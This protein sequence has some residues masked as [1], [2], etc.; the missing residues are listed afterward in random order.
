M[1]ASLIC[2]GD[3]QVDSTGK[4][5]LDLRGFCLTVKDVGQN[6]YHLFY[7][8]ADIDEYYERQWRDSNG[9]IKKVADTTDVFNINQIELITEK[10]AYTVN[11]RLGNRK[12]TI[13]FYNPS[14]DSIA[15]FK[16]PS[17]LNCFLNP[18]YQGGECFLDVIFVWRT[19][20][21][22]LG[23][24]MSLEASIRWI[25]EKIIP[26]LGGNVKLGN[27]T[28]FGASMHCADNF[29]MRQMIANIIEND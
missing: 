24:P 14:D 23:L 2:F 1:L 11:H 21:C 13:V 9:V 12:L 22:L 5:I 28:Y 27:Y 8:R 29:I 15:E 26:K 3:K 6:G 17:L 19:N 7:R 18:R 25:H 4:N 16:T 20:E 10:L